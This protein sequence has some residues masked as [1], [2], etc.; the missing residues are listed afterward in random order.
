MILNYVAQG[1][2]PKEATEKNNEFIFA[3]KAD[4][5]TQSFDNIKRHAHC[6][7]N[8]NPKMCCIPEELY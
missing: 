7:K 5:K 3:E 1:R 6:F 4:Y 8:I 2:R